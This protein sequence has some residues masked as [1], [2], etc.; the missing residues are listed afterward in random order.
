MHFL[1]HASVALSTFGAASCTTQAHQGAL[2]Q[3]DKQRL[4][5]R[6]FQTALRGPRLRKAPALDD[7]LLAYDPFF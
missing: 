3:L 7:A 6:I 2:T 5:D 1:L 4:H